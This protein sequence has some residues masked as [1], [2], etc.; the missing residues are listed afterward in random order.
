MIICNVKQKLRND[1]NGSQM[2]S[3]LL[4]CTR[5]FPPLPIQRCSLLRWS[6]YCLLIFQPTYFLAIKKSIMEKTLLKYCCFLWTMQASHTKRPLEAC[7][8]EQFLCM[9][10]STIQNS[11]I[12]LHKIQSVP[13]LQHTRKCLVR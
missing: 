12:K 4:S 11:L 6:N 10:V 13:P 1:C 7:Q 5:K 3:E 8:V 9:E 2:A